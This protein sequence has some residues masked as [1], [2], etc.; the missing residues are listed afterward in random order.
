MNSWEPLLEKIDSLKA[1]DISLPDHIAIATKKR[2]EEKARRMAEAQAAKA[3]ET[4]GS[5]DKGAASVIDAYY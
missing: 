2:A 5:T 3:K 1:T 4:K